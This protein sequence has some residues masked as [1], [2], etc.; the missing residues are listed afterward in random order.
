MTPSKLPVQLTF[1]TKAMEY[2]QA[3]NF[4]QLYVVV[5]LHEESCVQIF[6]PKI[7]PIVKEIDSKSIAKDSLEISSNGLQ[8]FFSPEFIHRF[9]PEGLA[10]EIIF[11]VKGLLKKRIEI[12]NI[13]PIIINI[14]KVDYSKH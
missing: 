3:K 7:I 9:S 8:V 2:M 14:C 1:H 13:D 4:Q 11:Q 10:G 6:S 5:D 12:T